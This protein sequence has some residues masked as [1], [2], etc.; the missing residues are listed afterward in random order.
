MTCVALAMSGTVAL[1][2]WLLPPTG[3]EIF[4]DFVPG[5]FWVG[6]AIAALSVLAATVKTAQRIRHRIALGREVERGFLTRRRKV[7]LTVAALLAAGMCVMP[8]W[9]RQ[10]DPPLRP[11]RRGTDLPTGLPILVSPDPGG[12]IGY[13]FIFDPPASGRW[14]L[15]FGILGLQLTI[16][17]LLTVPVL[18][19]RRHRPRPSEESRA[20]LTHP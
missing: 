18:L 13:W 1:F 5:V 2:G 11:S 16:L 4:R 6:A 3:R 14:Q 20:G 9:T 8:P 19:W 17:G 7:A 10:A 15:D 12:V